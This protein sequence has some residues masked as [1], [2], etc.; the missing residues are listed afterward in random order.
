MGMP[1]TSKRIERYVVVRPV[2]D[3]AFKGALDPLAI[4]LDP[5]YIDINVHD[6]AISREHG[7]SRLEFWYNH[8][9]YKEYS[10]EIPDFDPRTVGDCLIRLYGKD[11]HHNEQ[12]PVDDIYGAVLCYYRD[13]ECF[14]YRPPEGT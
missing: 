11:L 2:D 3:L 6:L 8:G 13:A 4:V 10:L 9:L 12:L 14:F 7:V 1:L 5:N